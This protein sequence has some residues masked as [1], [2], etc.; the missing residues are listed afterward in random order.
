MARYCLDASALVIYLTDERFQADLNKIMKEIESGKSKGILSVI[1]LA[2]FHRAITR[3][4]SIGS[5]DTYVTWLKESKIEIVSPTIETSVLASTKKQK[6]ASRQN[7]FAWGD[8]F[9]LATALDNDAE[10][11]ITADPDF[12]IVKEVPVIFC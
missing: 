3:I 6:Y 12:K 7:P 1:N 2:E 9:C 10:Y 11:I 5:A 8:A 4:F